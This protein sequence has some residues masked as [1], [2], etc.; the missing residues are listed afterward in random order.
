METLRRTALCGTTLA[1]AQCSTIRLQLFKVA[2]VVKESVRRLVFSLSS[3]FPFRDCW[4][5]IFSYFFIVLSFLRTEWRF[6]GKVVGLR[7]G[8]GGGMPKSGEKRLPDRQKQEND[9]PT[10]KNNKKRTRELSR[11]GALRPF[12]TFRDE[13]MQKTNAF[14]IFLCPTLRARDEDYT[15]LAFARPLSYPIFPV[16]KTPDGLFTIEGLRLSIH[17]PLAPLKQCQNPNVVN[18]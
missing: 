16:L 14:P 9:R 10:T 15:R 6:N 7:W 11:I 2:A 13:A 5:R 8:K 4:H 18:F 1:K 3:A 12:G 17:R